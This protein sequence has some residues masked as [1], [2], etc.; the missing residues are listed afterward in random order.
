MIPLSAKQIKEIS[1]S[2]AHIFKLFKIKANCKEEVAQNIEKCVF[3]NIL[4]NLLSKQKRLTNPNPLCPTVQL[5]QK[6]CFP[7]KQ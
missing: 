3:L 4:R 6:P 1:P 2:E 5:F 7:F